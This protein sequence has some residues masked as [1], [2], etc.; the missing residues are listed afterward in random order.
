MIEEIIH[1]IKDEL[2][3]KEVFFMK[4]SNTSD[5]LKSIEGRPYLSERE[6]EN[7]KLDTHINE[8]LKEEGNYREL[9][10]AIQDIRKKEGLTPSDMIILSLETN[11]EGKKLIQKFEAEIKKTVLASEIKLKQNNGT[12]TRINDLVFKISIQK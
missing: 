2:N 7:I 10:R 8:E 12:E 9:V 4:Q 3:I 6:I 5:S 1:F 11:E